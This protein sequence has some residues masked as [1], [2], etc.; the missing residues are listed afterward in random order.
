MLVGEP[1]AEALAAEIV[2]R[3]LN[4]RDVEAMA[5]ERAHKSA[6]KPASG[7]QVGGTTTKNAD[8]LAV[9]KR[10]SDTL[11]L[12]VDIEHRRGGGA[13]TVRYRSLEQLDEV[14][15]RLERKS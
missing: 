2:A 13:L 1:D 9:E 12:T 6:K 3:G 5:R 11:G 7:N 14:I 10:L 15:R 4:V 8:T